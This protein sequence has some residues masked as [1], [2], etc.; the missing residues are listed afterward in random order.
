[1]YRV[2]TKTR[3]SS[4]TF[5]TG[6]K[7]GYTTKPRRA[8]CSRPAHFRGAMH[9]LSKALYRPD[10]T[11]NQAPEQV[12]SA[13]AMRGPDYTLAEADTYSERSAVAAGGPPGASSE[14]VA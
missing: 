14:L 1:M 6:A 11:Q 5:R 4:I 10:R 8:E 2:S 3:E 12:L 13:D 7:H 9:T